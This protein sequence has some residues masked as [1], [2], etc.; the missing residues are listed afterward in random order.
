MARPIA[1]AIVA[2]AL[3]GA[4][5]PASKLLLASLTPWQLAGLLY[6]GAALGVLPTA[7]RAGGLRLPGRTDRLN[8]LRLLGATVAGG[9]LAPVLL[10]VGLRLA[11]AASV[12]LW[13]N[14]EVAATALLGVLLF[15][16]QLGVVGWAG[17]AAAGAAAIVLSMPGGSAGPVAGISVLLA[18]V[19]WGLDNHLT[20]LIDGITPAQSTFWKGLVAGTTNVTLG[21]IVGPWP[22]E[23][24]P[25]AAG[26]F[27]GV[28][29]YG[30]S[31]VLYVSAAQ[32][33][34][35]TRAQA[36]FASAPFFGAVLSTLLLGES[37]GLVHLL[38]G[39]LFG[40]SVTLLTLDRHSHGHDHA[41]VEH[42]HAHR[43]DDGHHAHEHG[44]VPGGTWHTHR[45]RHGSAAHDH[46]HWPDLHH[47]HGH[48]G[49]GNTE[50]AR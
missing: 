36:A 43:H 9:I 14:F 32:S 18:C 46:P 41:V 23:W 37:L 24:V 39:L 8:R 28:W 6:L 29:A 49:P 11:A 15:R 33:L 44:S 13:L 17:L 21:V 47:R 2:A 3:F 1:L 35:A 10:L 5:T 38:A 12:S 48:A 16:D 25:V 19:C 42:E 26:L 34:G 4:A 40:A 22:S 30:A 7:W 45:H 50:A 20:A 27:I 31:I